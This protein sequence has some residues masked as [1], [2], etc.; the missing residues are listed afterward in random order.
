MK[1]QASQDY[2]T[3]E[4][5]AVVVVWFDH[6]SA[7]SLNKPDGTV[8][9]S[10]A[11]P[12]QSRSVALTLPLSSLALGRN[13]LVATMEGGKSPEQQASVT[14]VVVTVLPPHPYNA[15]C[16][17][18]VRLRLIART[19]HSSIFTCPTHLL[20]PTQTSVLMCADAPRRRS[21]RGRPPF[22]PSGLLLLLSC[23]R[24]AAGQ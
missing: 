24:H 19:T 12:E 13:L 17:V 14:E 1:A 21:A 8:L 9:S 2:Y 5:H 22:L 10:T 16:E 6:A 18:K 11:P 3:T 20:T 15:A 4:A 7:I 23:G